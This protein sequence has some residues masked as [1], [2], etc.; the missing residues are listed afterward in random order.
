MYLEATPDMSQEPWSRVKILATLK[1]IHRLC[2]GESKCN[3]VVVGGGS[4]Q[5]MHSDMLN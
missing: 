1:L 4:L 3:I 5:K 2:H